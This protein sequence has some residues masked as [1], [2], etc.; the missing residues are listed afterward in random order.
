[1]DLTIRPA[2][3]KDLPVLVKMGRELI[4]YLN[5]EEKKRRKTKLLALDVKNADKVW[6][7]YYTKNLKSDKSLFLVALKKGEIVGMGMGRIEKSP[8]VFKIKE[9][10][11]IHELFVKESCRRQ[12]VCQA[13]IKRLESFFREK[14]VGVVHISVE[15]YN[16]EA[17]NLYYKLGYQDSRFLLHKEI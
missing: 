12:G 3:L 6:K 17:L 15:N 11:Q 16:T 7:K 4:L 9:F 5:R 8:P 10:G 14:G 1:M 2:N 13:L